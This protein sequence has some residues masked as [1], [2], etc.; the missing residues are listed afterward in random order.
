MP[1]LPGGDRWDERRES[2]QTTVAA[3]RLRRVDNE[4]VVVGRAGSAAASCSVAVKPDLRL[5]V[6]R[7]VNLSGEFTVT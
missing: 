1:G 7:H 6:H 5:T 4:S 3:L 2:G